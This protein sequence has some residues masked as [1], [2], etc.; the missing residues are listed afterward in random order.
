M[1]PLPKREP[2]SWIK[3]R[4]LL[5]GGRTGL[6]IFFGHIPNAPGE[7]RRWGES[8]TPGTWLLNQ[9]DNILR[10]SGRCFLWLTRY[11]QVSEEHRGRNCFGKTER[12]SIGSCSFHQNAP[13]GG[14]KGGI[15]TEIFCKRLKQSVI[16]RE[17]QLY[18]IVEYS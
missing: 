18:R 4:E 11:R 6:R 7:I 15:G 17:Q 5:R 8:G 13:D 3:K 2:G 10:V 1:P 9:N 12:A 16:L 14:L